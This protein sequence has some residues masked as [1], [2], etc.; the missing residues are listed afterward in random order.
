M[1]RPIAIIRWPAD[2]VY[3]GSYDYHG[4]RYIDSHQAHARFQAWFTFLGTKVTLCMT[5][6]VPFFDASAS[7]IGTCAKGRRILCIAKCYPALNHAR[8]T[9][10]K[11][12]YVVAIYP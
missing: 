11:T 9:I 8:I 2:T 4:E 5:K 3:S 1:P 7:G 10:L 12:P 6:L